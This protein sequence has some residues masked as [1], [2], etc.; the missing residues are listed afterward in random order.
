MEVTDTRLQ[1]LIDYAIALKLMAANGRGNVRDTADIVAALEELQGY[2]Q[3]AVFD[4]KPK[5]KKTNQ[6]MPRPK[7]AA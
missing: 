6:P 1:Q 7:R 5:Q 3:F 2:R 4:Q